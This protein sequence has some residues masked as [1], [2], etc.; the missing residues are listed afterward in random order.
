MQR[1]NYRRFLSVMMILT[2]V[3]VALLTGGVWIQSTTHAASMIF[4]V[5]NT[6]DAGAGSLRQAIMDAET[7][8]GNTDTIRFAIGSGPQTITLVTALPICEF[9][10]MGSTT[11]T[12]KA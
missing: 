4:T 11:A 8:A 5:T 10:G 9:V 12:P 6:N 7:N 2:I 1:K 3:T